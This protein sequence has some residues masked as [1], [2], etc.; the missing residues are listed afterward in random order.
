MP[1]AFLKW[2]HFSQ[3]TP[4]FPVGSFVQGASQRELTPEEIAAYD[5]P[6]PE[7]AYKEGPR[8]MPSLVPTSTDDPASPANIAAWKTLMAFERPWLTAFSDG[9]P[10]TAGAER[11][12]QK[13]IPGAQGQPHTT[14]RG[15]HFLQEDSGPELAAL[16]VGFVSA[17]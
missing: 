11:P 17:S 14:V 8:M 5:A 3:T 2:Q 9:D 4:E 13:L 15:G 1:E 10:I 16:I 6:F 7:E 12:F